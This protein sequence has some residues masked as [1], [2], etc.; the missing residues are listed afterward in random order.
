[1]A[2]HGGGG[3]RDEFLTWTVSNATDMSSGTL[4]MTRVIPLSTIAVAFLFKHSTIVDTLIVQLI[5]P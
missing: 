2:A 5:I 3:F 4:G 1:M